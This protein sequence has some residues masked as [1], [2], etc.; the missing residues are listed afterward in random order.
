[1]DFKIAGKCFVKQESGLVVDASGNRLPTKSVLFYRMSPFII[2]KDGDIDNF[3]GGKVD[4][5]YQAGGQYC[6]FFK[7]QVKKLQVEKS[8]SIITSVF[9]AITGTRHQN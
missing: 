3:T 9:Q 4:A 5:I 6:D 7:E 2:T 8:Q 1:M